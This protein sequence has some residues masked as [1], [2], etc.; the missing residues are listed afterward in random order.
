MALYHLGY[1]VPV[2]PKEF[3]NR[4]V[5]VAVHYFCDDWWKGDKD[6][7]RAMDKSRNRRDLNWFEAFSRGLLLGLLSERWQDVARVCSWVEADLRPEYMGDEI[8]DE[9]VHVYRSVAAGL[10]P[11][12][13]PGLEKCEAKILKCRLQRPRLLFQAWD[14]ARRKDQ[15]A[16]NVS[17]VK[18]LEHFDANPGFRPIAENWIATHQ[19]VVA[20]AARRLGLALPELPPKLEAV[21]LTRES[22]GLSPSS[23]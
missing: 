8:E 23:R 6:A 5:A 19:S 7:T 4:G 12:P 18:S 20:L 9:L 22:L 13:M 1:N 10:R 14:A 3:L 2:R 16:F 11:E 15:A 21:L 17:L